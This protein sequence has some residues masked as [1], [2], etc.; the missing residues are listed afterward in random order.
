MARYFKIVEIDSDS[1]IEATG[2]DLDCNQLVVAPTN[3]AV[4]VAVDDEEY[5][6]FIDMDMFEG[7]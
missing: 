7:D 5:E 3:D 4:Y 6:M 1:F 2:E